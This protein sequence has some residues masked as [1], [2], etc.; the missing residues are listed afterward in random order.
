MCRYISIQQQ[1]ML[2]LPCRGPQDGGVGIKSA[3]MEGERHMSSVFGFLG[4]NRAGF[5]Q[6]ME[7]G[8][9]CTIRKDRLTA[10]IISRE[11]RVSLSVV[12]RKVRRKKQRP[13]LFCGRIAL[14]HSSIEI[15][16]FFVRRIQQ[17]KKKSTW[18]KQVQK[19]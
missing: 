17:M 11:Y 1:R 18:R 7:F 14:V 9:F 5:L 12:E 19:I 8:D 10:H 4:E 15:K 6:K 13:T 16:I 2:S 3:E